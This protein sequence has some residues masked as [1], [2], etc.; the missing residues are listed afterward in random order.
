[1][2]DTPSVRHLAWKCL[3]RWSQG[4]IFAETLIARAAAE[5]KLPHADR[6]LLQAIVYDTLRHMSWLDHIRKTLRPGKL[7][8]KIRWLVLVGLCQLFV[9]RQAEHAA[10]GETVRLAPQRVRG[11]VN[12]MLRN[13]V[14]RKAEFDAELEKLPLPVR[15]ST[16]SWLVKRWLREFG[17]ADTRAMLEW[18]SLTPP[19]YARLNPQN[20][21][22]EIPECWEP[23]PLLPLW[24]RLHGPLPLEAL[25]AGQLYVTD[26][27]TRYCVKLLAPQP[28]ERVLDAC[29]APGGKSAAML[30]A[31]G[32]DLH[33]LATDVEEFRLKPLR[34]N[35][36]RAGGRDV[37]VAQH[38]WTQPCPAEW[39]SAFDAVLLDVP[40]SN[41]G[42]LQ[43]RVDARW[44][45]SADEIARLAALQLQILEQ[46]C[47]AVR[48]GGRLVY[49]TCSI[50]R[51]E[52]RAVVDAFLATHKDF[53][54]VEEYL[55]LPHREQAD[56][57]Y[58]ALLQRAE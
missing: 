24:Y 15:F 54:F 43:R 11:V 14:R 29:A 44:R 46:A 26:P 31:T 7:E 45:L 23:L 32:G 58:A 12:G 57:A 30:A 2:S 28:G 34:E 49:S 13:A 21:P 5:H 51:E 16:P 48:P 50:D 56:G 35:L 27:S 25:R 52:D 1:M 55:A 39:C 47:A 18:N 53:T 38:D 3:L 36:L 22:A 10:V 41:S 42:V 20:P 6:S 9:L 4:G 40:C 17:E 19:V 37:Q 33:L 8:E